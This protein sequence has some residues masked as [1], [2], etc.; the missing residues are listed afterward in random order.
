MLVQIDLYDFH[1][2]KMRQVDHQR[3]LMVITMNCLQLLHIPL[4]AGRFAAKLI[5]GNIYHMCQ[6]ISLTGNPHGG[7]IDV[8]NDSAVIQPALRSER[9]DPF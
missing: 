9:K 6:H 8:H 3:R 1:H 2:G 5:L 4:I 7:I